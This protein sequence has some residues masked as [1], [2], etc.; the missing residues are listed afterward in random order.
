MMTDDHISRVQ[1][2]PRI[3]R[4]DHRRLAVI[5]G[6]AE[7]RETRAGERALLDEVIFGPP[8]L[9]SKQKPPLAANPPLTGFGP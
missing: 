8:E 5:L 9:M 7:Q 4:N 1:F 3:G 6:A 2:K